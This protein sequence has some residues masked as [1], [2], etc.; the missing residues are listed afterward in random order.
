MNKHNNWGKILDYINEDLKGTDYSVR[1]NEEDG[2]YNCEICKGGEVVETYAENYYEEELSDLMAE[3]WPYAVR[4]SKS[5]APK[6]KEVHSV[7]MR[8]TSYTDRYD[9]I[10]NAF[11]GVYDNMA[12]A[13]RRM[14]E[15]AESK[16]KNLKEIFAE[17]D[18]KDQIFFSNESEESYM[19]LLV[20]DDEKYEYFVI[21]TEINKPTHEEL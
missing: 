11:I 20:G 1:V 5:S 3:V 15:E 16:E 2:C 9:G 4:L 6:N 10:S 17:Y 18:M 14:R 8:H 12:D 19:E 13:I 21:S 7:F